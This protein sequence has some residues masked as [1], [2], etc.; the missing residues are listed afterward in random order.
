MHIDHFSFRHFSCSS[1]LFSVPF[2]SLC[3]AFSVFFP[4][5][6]T[7]FPILCTSLLCLALHDSYKCIFSIFLSATF[8]AFSRLFPLFPPYLNLASHASTKCVLPIFLS[9]PLP[10]LPAFTC[11]PCLVLINAYCPSFFPS[12]FSPFSPFFRVFLRHI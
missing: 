11:M 4:P 7:P 5:L 12:L 6:C 2:S 9:V 3:S 10:A 1:R 8:L